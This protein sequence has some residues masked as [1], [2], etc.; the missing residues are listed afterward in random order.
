MI[1]LETGLYVRIVEL[2]N[3]PHPLP[4][5]SGFSVDKAYRIL[6]AF[7]ASESSDAFLILANDR[8]EMWFICNRHLRV[9]TIDNSQ[10][11]FSLPFT[12]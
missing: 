10:T 6:G 11:A 12:S 2:E 4:L 9:V 3:G 7:N 1:Y 5:S 8:K